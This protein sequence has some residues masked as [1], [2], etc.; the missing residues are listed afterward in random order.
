MEI[1]EGFVRS[2]IE[3]EID[4]R[5]LLLENAQYNS[6]LGSYAVCGTEHVTLICVR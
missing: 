3:S 5:V 4:T 6:K 2:L 1:F